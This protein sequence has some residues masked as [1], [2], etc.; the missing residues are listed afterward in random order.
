MLCYVM[1]C[2]VMLCY[3]MLCYVMLCY[4]MLCYVMLCY[5]MLCYVMLCDCFFVRPELK[6][7]RDFELQSTGTQTPGLAQRI[8]ITHHRDMCPVPQALLLYRCILGNTY[9][10]R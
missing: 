4:V 2:Y 3:V 8:Y 1:L 5:V 10:C 9:S 7:Y 6:P